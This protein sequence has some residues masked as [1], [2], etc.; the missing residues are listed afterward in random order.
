M[1]SGG[2]AVS[3]RGYGCYGD[4]SVLRVLC[5]RHRRARID[6]GKTLMDPLGGAPS[7]PRGRSKIGHFRWEVGETIVHIYIIVSILIA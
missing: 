6:R 2:R 7:S 1:F 3:L 5:V 4:L